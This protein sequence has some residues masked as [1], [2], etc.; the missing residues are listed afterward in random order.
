MFISIS[1]LSDEQKK[2]IKALGAHNRPAP[3]ADG[4][5]F[6]NSLTFK[7]KLAIELSKIG[8]IE[9]DNDYVKLSR[10]GYGIFRKF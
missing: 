4:N 10:V 3:L 9:I 8:L 5:I 2:I 1:E 6:T 7:L